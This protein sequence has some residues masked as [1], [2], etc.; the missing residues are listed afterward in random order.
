MMFE[1]IML[2]MLEASIQN[3]KCET[4]SAYPLLHLFENGS[5]NIACTDLLN[6]LE[7]KTKSIDKETR[8]LH[9]ASK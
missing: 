9:F 3:G 7:N 8:K 6:I 2:Q 5:C 4:N 1:D